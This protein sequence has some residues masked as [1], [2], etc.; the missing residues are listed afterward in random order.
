[1][2]I[3]MALSII[4]LSCHVTAQNSL[5]VPSADLIEKTV[6]AALTFQQNDLPSLQKAQ[7][8]FTAE[9]WAEFMK[10]M[11]GFLD[12]NGAPTFT[13][14]FVP[15][16]HATITKFE[17]GITNAKLPGTLTQT[18]DSS[19]TTYR[20]RIEVQTVG[21]QPKISHLE[22]ITCFGA[23]AAKYCM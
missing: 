11:Q 9:G 23:A 17:D 16:A 1:M 12:T 3:F 22:Q 10:K 7:S 19:K 6:V 4:A 2:K 5:P 21:T 14:T 20:L 15:A 8:N 18:H 13:S